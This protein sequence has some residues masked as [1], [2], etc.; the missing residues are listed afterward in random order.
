M[1]NK[2]FSDWLSNHWNILYQQARRYFHDW[3]DIEEAAQRGA[4]RLW[5]TLKERE[6]PPGRIG[7]YANTAVRYT[8]LNMLKEADDRGEVVIDEK[9]TAVLQAPCTAYSDPG[10]LWDSP[11]V[12]CLTANERALAYMIYDG[13]TAREIARRW[14][15]ANTDIVYKEISKLREKLNALQ[16]SNHRTLPT[17]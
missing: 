6:V 9:L 7:A 3:D 16:S 8:C 13:L 5:T 4:V 11:L 2:D 15:V 17:R 10:D 14:Y 12:K 1:N